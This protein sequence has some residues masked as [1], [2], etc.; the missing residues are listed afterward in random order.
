MCGAEQPA[1]KAPHFTA[2][3]CHFLPS[4][5]VQIFSVL[6]ARTPSACVRTLMRL[7]FSPIKQTKFCKE[8]F[9]DGKLCMLENMEIGKGT[10]ILINIYYIMTIKY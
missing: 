2:F 8:F 4:S 9:Q 1:P 10:E 7:G 3:C 6:S 5:Y